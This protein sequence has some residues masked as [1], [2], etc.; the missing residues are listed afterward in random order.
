MEVVGGAH[1]DGDVGDVIVD[2]LV[3]SWPEVPVVDDGAV[4]PA[5]REVLVA[6]VSNEATEAFAVVNKPEWRPDV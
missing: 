2:C 4:A 1:A 5:G 3:G 6:V